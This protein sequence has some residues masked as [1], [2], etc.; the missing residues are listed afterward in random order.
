MIALRGHYSKSSIPVWLV[1]ACWLV[2]TSASLRGEAYGQA[3]APATDGDQ[4]AAA[5]LQKPESPEALCEKIIKELAEE[6]ANPKNDPASPQAIEEMIKNAQANPVQSQTA[7]KSGDPA[8]VRLTD[9]EI[10]TTATYAF[11]RMRFLRTAAN[12]YEDDGREALKR[13]NVV[14]AMKLLGQARQTAHTI[15]DDL[16]TIGQPEASTS[17]S[18]GGRLQFRRGP[19][20]EGL[21]RMDAGGITAPPGQRSDARRQG[22]RGQGFEGIARRP[23]EQ[24]PLDQQ[25]RPD[26]I[27]GAPTTPQPKT[28]Q[29]LAPQQPP[30]P[31]TQAVISQ[32]IRAYDR[33]HQV[34]VAGDGRTAVNV[35]PLTDAM[36]SLGVKD[37][38]APLVP[39]V[40]GARQTWGFT[41]EAQRV[42]SQ[43]R[44]ELTKV[45]GVALDV[46]FQ[47][48][49]LVGVPGMRVNGPATVVDNP[50]MISLQR[51]FE[52]ARQ[53]TDSQEHWQSLPESIRYPGNISRVRGFV[54]DPDRQDVFVVGTLAASHRDRIDIDTLIIALSVVWKQGLVPAVSLDPLPDNFGG[55]QFPRIM[56]I[57]RDSI[58]AKIMLD[59][60]YEMKAIMLGA[61]SVDAPRFRSLKDLSA[62]LMDDRQVSSRFWFYP[63]PLQPDTVHVSATRRSVLFE[64]KLEVL[65]EQILVENASF[66]S[67]GTADS[68]AQRA[69]DLFTSSFGTLEASEIPQ[70]AGIY[71]R[72]HGVTDVVTVCKLLRLMSIDYAILNAI[73]ELPYR[74]LSP[75]EGVP[76]SYKGITV[77]YR[78]S[79]AMRD[80]AISGGAE[81]RT[82]AH[83]R[84]FDVYQDF[85]TTTLERAAD[86][87]GSFV[88]HQ[89][90]SLSFAIP[91]QDAANDARMQTAKL[92]ASH[93]LDSGQYSQAA[94]EFE[95]LTELDPLDVDAWLNLAL[96]KSYLGR[97]AEAQRSIDVARFVD[98]ADSMVETIALDIAWRANPNLEIRQKDPTLLKTLS[99]EY[100]SR[101]MGALNAKRIDAARRFAD[102]AIDL[103]KENA[104][105]Y[106]A[107]YWVANELDIKV[108]RADLIS[109]IRI[110]RQ[111]RAEPGREAASRSR[112]AIA[113]ALSASGRGDRLRARMEA[114]RAA[115]G[116]AI[117]VGTFLDELRRAADEAHEAQNLDPTN[118]LGFVVE[119][120]ARAMRV[121]I[122]RE[123]KGPFNPEPV[124]ALAEATVRKYPEFPFAYIARGTLAAALNDLSSAEDDFTKA[125]ALDATLSDAFL[126][127][128]FVRKQR[129]ECR[130]AFEDLARAKSLKVAMLDADEHEIHQCK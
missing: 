59:A 26:I 121:S 1:I 3:Q 94:A 67:T 84:S 125:I 15:R 66:V 20:M 99:D 92:M 38:I 90:V 104:E 83:V 70:P 42:L 124:R 127:R 39:P 126:A 37:P 73:S 9:A 18:P 34:L 48:L 103:W 24:D 56:N 117:E 62:E 120:V 58:V 112:L 46:T 109:A 16:A 86:N 31:N 114:V 119:V 130:A 129:G 4:Q 41:P 12:R 74:R 113:L 23:S 95:R 43:S 115:G 40:P 2:M 61:R 27:L 81:L 108:S 33:E 32:D 25:R 57:P 7:E 28:P 65:T 105:A 116:N 30:Q 6:K 21:I 98:S 10:R 11:D 78:G 100:T 123:E 36:A 79:A 5:A 122:F 111:Q 45:G 72:L 89:Q 44:D 50:V 128:A 118:P 60:D 69:A 87:Y 68:I 13:G 75:T 54:L 53:Y 64:S 76:A 14:Q 49:A 80:W 102:R 93:S 55:P 91:A 35:K 101:A 8:P 52:T 110:L 106:I 19:A 47:S 107:R 77:Q 71:R 22:A 85:A 17:D 63:A 51:L 29:R 82:R 97:H 96:S 88:L